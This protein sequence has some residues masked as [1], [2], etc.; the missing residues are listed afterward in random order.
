VVREYSLT[1]NNV[2]TNR[3]YVYRLKMVDLDGSTKYSNEVLVSALGE[4][5]SVDVTPNPV[6]S[7]AVATVVA[8]STGD[9]VVSLV[10][11]SGRDIQEVYSGMMNQGE[12][13]TLQIDTRTIA[14]GSYTLVV[15]QSGVVV[16]VK[17]INIVK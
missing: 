11:I 3:A 12:A 6:V 17:R 1:D 13:K 8:P 10:D 5:G 4:S 16:G 14:S 9:A 2:S 7:E 15:R